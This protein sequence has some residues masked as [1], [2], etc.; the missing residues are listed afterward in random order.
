[1]KLLEYLT[2]S[3]LKDDDVFLLDGADG[4]RNIK[5]STLASLLKAKNEIKSSDQLYD[6]LDSLGLPTQVR[7][8]IYRGKYLGT[9]LTKEQAKSIANGSFKGLFLG[10]YWVGKSLNESDASNVE[11]ISYQIY[12][13]NYWWRKGNFGPDVRVSHITLFPNRYSIYNTVGVPSQNTNNGYLGLHIHEYLQQKMPSLVSTFL[14]NSDD[15]LT[16]QA[17]LTN[18][19]T[20]GVA[21]SSVFVD[22]VKFVLPSLA[23]LY[24]YTI[25]TNQF[26]GGT[27]SE[28][29]PLASIGGWEVIRDANFNGILMRDLAPGMYYLY[30]LASNGG[31]KGIYNISNAKLLLRPVF[32]ITGE[33]TAS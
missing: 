9:T 15:I 28:Q 5:Y 23:M 13:F 27:E 12:G 2:T 21:T 33:A 7:N 24:G 17:N 19:A 6:W 4:T 26:E 30:N 10:D 29:L 8:T 18:A 1:M 14:P 11:N 20:N 22:N 32:G 31:Q 16:R 25:S 3:V